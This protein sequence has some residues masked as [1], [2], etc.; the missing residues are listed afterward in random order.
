MVP[1]S[2]LILDE[3]QVHTAVA[4]SDLAHSLRAALNVRK[5]TIKDIFAGSSESS[6]RRMFG[7]AALG[8]IRPVSIAPRTRYPVASAICAIWMH[9][10][11]TTCNPL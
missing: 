6:L 10:I 11:T 4:H 1:E 9:L 5:Q 7:R 3:A 2:A 8:T